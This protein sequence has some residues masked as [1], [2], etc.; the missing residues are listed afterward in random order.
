[1]TI[2]KQAVVQADEHDMTDAGKMAKDVDAR[3]DDNENTDH[4]LQETL[5]EEFHKVWEETIK[6]ALEQ[7][8]HT[9]EDVLKN[10]SDFEDDFRGY[11]RDREPDVDVELLEE[12]YGDTL[13]KKSK[14]KSTD[15]KTTKADE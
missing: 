5:Q 13:R 3:D 7:L 4:D 11:L 1:M 2:R 9:T 8:K 10:F 6:P 15:S 12:I 14:N